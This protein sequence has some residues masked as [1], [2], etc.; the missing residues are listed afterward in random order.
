MM[1]EADRRILEEFAARV[2]A[3][4]PGA[5]IWAYGSRARG[6]AQPD[7]DFDIC[8]VIGKPETKTRDKVQHI[9][10]EVSFDHGIV[11]VALCYSQ[12]DFTRGPLSVSPLV[13]NILREGVAA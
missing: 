13:R 9:A 1:S 7:S 8:V 5:R 11:I 6:D 3:V 12:R 10:W 4:Y 2:R